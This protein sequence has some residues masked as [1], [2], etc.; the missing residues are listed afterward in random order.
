[1]FHCQYY[2]FQLR[3][4]FNA[5]Y[6]FQYQNL[7]LDSTFFPKAFII[8]VYSFKISLHP[9]SHQQ[10]R[11]S[12]NKG[13]Q[14]CKN[15]KKPNQSLHLAQMK[16]IVKSQSHSSNC[17]DKQDTILV[18]LQS[19]RYHC[20]NIKLNLLFNLYNKHKSFMFLYYLPQHSSVFSFLN[21]HKD[22]FF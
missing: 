16:V 21:I 12:D 3:F 15:C 13:K 2:I 20:T 10:I 4:C 6:Y 9:N 17:M 22:V 14:I 8:I 11:C 1:M 7:K 18:Q 19:H 5:R